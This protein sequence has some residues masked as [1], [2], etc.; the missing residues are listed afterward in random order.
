MGDSKNI[1]V[2]L[3]ILV[4]LVIVEAGALAMVWG[5][6]ASVSDDLDE[7][8]LEV[9][10]T[11]YLVNVSA[12]I[13]QELVLIDHATSEAA[14]ELQGRDLND[15]NAG[16]VLRAVANVSSNIVSV[17]TT[18]VNGTILTVQ[19]SSFSNIIGMD[20][21]YQDTMELALEQ[22]RSAISP[23]DWV[24]QGYYAVYMVYPVFDDE[25]KINGTIAPMF[26][27][28]WMIGNITEA[29]ANDELSIMTL[30]EDGVVL[31]DIDEGQIGRNTFTDPIYENFT[32]IKAIAHR[33]VDESSGV[34]SYSFIT[35][36]EEVRKEVIWTTVGLL[37]VQWTVSVIRLV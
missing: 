10:A 27:P 37:G 23:L 13:Q 28:D 31:Y 16:M 25:G 20:I 3:A 33:M 12:D 30:Q 15:S 14:T 2:I 8:I 21:S 26:R 22:G 19:P 17:L 6:M 1:N 9:E 35:S 4:A 29:Q 11:Q 7:Q 5:G 24:V 36:G 32:E 18:D 34:G